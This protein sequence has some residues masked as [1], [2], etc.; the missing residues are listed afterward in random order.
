MKDY[1]DYASNA[2]KN[3]HLSFETISYPTVSEAIE[4]LKQGKIDCV[5]PANLTYYDSEMQGLAMSPA[6][7]T[8]E[9]DSIVRSSDRSFIHTIVQ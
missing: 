2:L 6:I 8:T 3:A 1:L 5:F 7:M 4:D 9:M